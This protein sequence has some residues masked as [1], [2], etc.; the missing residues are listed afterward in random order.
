MKQLSDSEIATLEKAAA[1]LKSFGVNAGLSFTPPMYS[2][3]ITNFGFH[4]RHPAPEKKSSIVVG[5]GETVQE[6]IENCHEKYMVEKVSTPGGVQA[7]V[8]EIIG[9]GMSQEEMRE[10][11]EALPIRGL[12]A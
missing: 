8:R 9:S 12:G 10:A 5:Q 1:I 2:E 3:D 4:V 7:A 6:A 11:L